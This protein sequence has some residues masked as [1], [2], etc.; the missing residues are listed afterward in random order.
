MTKIVNG[1][2]RIK[3]M[4]WWNSMSYP[5]QIEFCLLNGVQRMPVTGREVQAV[6]EKFILKK[7]GVKLPTY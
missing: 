1:V 2:P 4:S 6:H 3:A 5:Q 7:D